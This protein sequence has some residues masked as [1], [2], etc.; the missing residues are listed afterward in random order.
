MT[1]EESQ[2]RWAQLPPLASVAPAGA[3]RPGAQILAVTAT[4][5]GELRPLIVTQRYGRG[6]TLVFAGE[7]SWRWRMMLPASDN[8]HELV[9]RQ[10]TRWVASGAADRIEIPTGSVALPG[11]TE[12]ISVLVRDEEH[13]AHHRCGGVA[14]GHRARRS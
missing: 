11:T 10:L 12:T 3:P 2:K 8:T 14:A 9:W 6:R 1:I 13:E 7:A 4:P 5:G